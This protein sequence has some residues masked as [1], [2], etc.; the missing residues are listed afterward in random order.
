MRRLQARLGAL[1][2]V[3]LVGCGAP[4]GVELT[5]QRAGVET[6]LINVTLNKPATASSTQGLFLPEYAVDGNITGDDSRWCPGI[7]IPTR[8]LDIDLQGTFDLVRME[9]YTG[10][11]DTKPIQNYELAYDDGTGWKL[12]P[13]ASQSAN[14]SVAVATTFTQTVMAKK[15]RLTCLDPLA[16]NCR[17]KELWVFG[18]P[19]TGTANLPPV[20]NAGPDASLTLP[21]NSL[22][23]S[24]SA[25]DSDGTIASLAWTQVAGPTATLSGAS[26]ATLSV[27]GLFAGV[28]TFRLTAT[29][30]DG[31]TASDDVSVTVTAPVAVSNIA[32]NKPVSAG[33]SS[34]TYVPAFAVDGSLTTRWESSYSFLTHNSFD[35]DLQG[36]HEVLSAELHLSTTATAS[37]AM[38]AFELQSW[39]GGCWRTIPGTVVEGN[40]LNGTVKSLTFTSP[41]ITTKVRL[42]CKDAPYCRLREFKLMGTPGAVLPTG[43]TTCAAG[44]QTVARGPRYDAAVFL[45]EHYNDDRTTQWP[46]IIALHGIGGS[47][48]NLEHTAVLSN[49]EGLAK[50]FNSASFRA[51]MQAIVIS[52]NQRMPVTNSG[53]GWFNANTLMALLEDAKKNYRVDADRVYFTGLSGGANTSI[54]LGMTQTDRL[55]AIVPIALTSTPTNDP[56][57]CVLKPLPIWAFHGALDTPGR[58]TNLKVWLDTKCG[59]GASAMRPVTVYPNGGHNGATWDTAYADLSLY[60]WLLQQRISDR[61]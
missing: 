23:L 51:A 47:T 29:D 25:T 55:A 18:T 6:A 26:T 50:Q 21:A 32:L 17:V 27:S 34:T 22:T 12:I 43:P 58:S 13:G 9:L 11:R 54:E 46:L 48:L 37:A 41:V 14:T 8:Q 56:N 2:T 49:P 1:V 10:F 40:P 38:T 31:A 44:Q 45:P 30:D 59:A 35:V 33:S 60:D 42:V 39:D 5:G 3:A 4:E 15:V 61:Q 20:A 24:G 16:D 19:H 52:P 28:S 7:Y 53:N 57:V 36:P